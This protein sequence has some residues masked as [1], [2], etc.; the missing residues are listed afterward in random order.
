MAAKRHA[1]AQ[2]YHRSCSSNFPVHYCLVGWMFRCPKN[3]CLY[4]AACRLL[5]PHRKTVIVRF[6]HHIIKDRG[7]RAPF[8]DL[9]SNSSVILN[10]RILGR[11]TRDVGGQK[12]GAG[13]WIGRE[14]RDVTTRNSRN[15]QSS[16][17][18]VM[19]TIYY[20]ILFYII[21]QYFE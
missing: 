3:L 12:E 10:A 13:R 7:Y 6:R 1:L 21:H 17:I 11:D 4:M 20:Q 5:P 19:A 16:Y 18:K 2:W 8:F 9:L 15:K 14:K